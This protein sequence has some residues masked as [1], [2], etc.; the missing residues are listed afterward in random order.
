MSPAD[1]HA[2]DS[3]TE[4]LMPSVQSAIDSLASARWTGEPDWPRFK[5]KMM[6]APTPRRNVIRRR[7]VLFG[8]LALMTLGAAAAAGQ[9]LYD[10]W[11]VEGFAIMDDGT[12]MRFEGQATVDLGDSAMKPTITVEGQ[13]LIVE[14]ETSTPANTTKPAR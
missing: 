2:P 11:Y 8:A 14:G 1:H 12:T 10:V 5:E 7:P 6:N 13:P 9:R 4:K 3:S